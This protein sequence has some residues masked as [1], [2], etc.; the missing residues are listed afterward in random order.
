MSQLKPLYDAPQCAVCR[1]DTSAGPSFMRLYRDQGRLEFC[2]PGCARVYQD[3]PHGYDGR[4][5]PTEGGLEHWRVRW[6][7]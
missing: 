7:K 4:G 2:T 5:E 6:G 3:K 1:R